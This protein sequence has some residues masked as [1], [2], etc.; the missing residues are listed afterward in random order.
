MNAVTAIG[1][2]GQLGIVVPDIAAA[3]DQYGRMFGIDDW[4]RYTY[5][6]SFVPQLRY[7]DSGATFSMHVA[8][9]DADPQI[10]LIEP[11]TGP[12]VYHEYLEHNAPGLHHLGVFVPSLDAAIATMKQHGYDL[13]QLGRGYG[14]DGDG[15]FAY[16]DTVH[17][18]H[19]VIEAIERPRRRRPPLADWVTRRTDER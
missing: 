4:Q 2:V 15:G 9:G 17:D 7:R 6:A 11:L 5:D 14:L 16:F 10:E 13:I 8:L 19:T 12:S 1:R 3:V 18:H